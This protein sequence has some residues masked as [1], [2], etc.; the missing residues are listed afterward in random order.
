MKA[1]IVAAI[2]VSG[3][4]CAFANI[5]SNK[6]VFV[7]E[8]GRNNAPEVIANIARQ[9]TNETQVLIAA[10]KA[11]AA[12]NA[13]TQ[14]TNV[15]A[16]VVAAIVAN[17]VVIYRK[18]CLSSFQPLVAFTDDDRLTIC[19]V[20]LDNANEEITIGYVCTADLGTTK[21]TV[22]ASDV[23]TQK[24]DF[25]EMAD[26]DVS[27]VTLH[28]E[29][30]EIGGQTYSQWYSV[31]IPK[32]DDAEYFYYIKMDGD[33]QGGSGYTL[34]IANGITGGYTGTVTDGSFRKTYVGGILMSATEVE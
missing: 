8:Q 23:L 9:T 26:S 2:T 17:E 4:F 7:D 33:T 16:D 11:D 18:G 13:A 27:E 20:S 12:S 30:R 14:A 31:T 21:P 32:P 29:E 28:N 22:R 15:V 24:K 10:A 6:V 19:E 1:L 5:V 25:G 34:D 3:A